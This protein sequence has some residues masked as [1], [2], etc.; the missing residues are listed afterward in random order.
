MRSL[1]V[2]IVIY[3][4]D[5][6][7]FLFSSLLPIFPVLSPLIINNDKRTTSIEKEKRH[8]MTKRLIK[9]WLTNSSS[10]HVHRRLT[11]VSVSVCQEIDDWQKGNQSSTYTDEDEEKVWNIARRHRGDL[12]RVEM[13]RRSLSARRK[14]SMRILLRSSSD[15]LFATFS[16]RSTDEKDKSTDNS[17]VSVAERR[18]ITKQARARLRFVYLS[19]PL[20]NSPTFRS[21]NLLGRS[22]ISKCSMRSGSSWPRFPTAPLNCFVRRLEIL[23]RLEEKKTN[24][25]DDRRSSRTAGFQLFSAEEP[26]AWALKWRKDKRSISSMWLA[27]LPRPSDRIARTHAW[28]RSRWC[29]RINLQSSWRGERPFLTRFPSRQATRFQLEKSARNYRNGTRLSFNVSID[30]EWHFEWLAN[31]S[32]SIFTFSRMFSRSCLWTSFHLSLSL[33][34]SRSCRFL[35]MIDFTQ[36][37]KRKLIFSCSKQMKVIRGRK[38]KITKPQNIEA[39]LTFCNDS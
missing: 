30:H 20:M 6:P 11:S 14:A 39:A 18:K 24:L 35:L 26:Y 17:T 10:F 9:Q 34:R 12:T 28:D 8:S 38:I 13:E 22:S 31:T 36:E 16:S 19:P 37:T 4:A 3:T 1:F 15:V 29:Q 23:V 7:F 32:L 27:H 33:S 21:C 25:D 5:A 2:Q